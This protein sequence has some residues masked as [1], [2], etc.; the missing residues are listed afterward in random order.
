[1][2]LSQVVRPGPGQF[3][4]E[5]GALNY[6][7]QKL[8]SFTDP[9]IITGELSYQ[10]FKKHYSGSLDLP[11]F[12]YDGTASHE[13]MERLSSLIKGTDCVVGIGGGRALDTAKGTAALLKV[14]Y[15]TIPTVLGTCSAYTP[16]SAVYHPDHT[17]KVVDYYEKA[18]LLCLMDL[19]LL[20]E[21][22]KNY[23]MGGIGDTLAKWYEAEG[24]TRH[25]EGN[26][27]AMVQVGLRTAKATQEL[28]LKDSTEALKSLEN[29][30][31]TDAFKRVAETVIAIAGTVGGFAGEYGRMAGAHAVHNGMSL[32]QETHV[33]EHGVKVAYGVLIQLWASGDEKEVRKLL[34][35]FESN[36]FPH[37][38]SDFAVKNNFLEKAKKVAAFAASD[39]ETFKL[40]VPGVTKE[41]IFEAMNAVEDFSKSVSGNY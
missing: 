22:P 26:L 35:F 6:L 37:R 23:F 32:I 12:Q 13:D 29:T 34:L 10:A 9:I 5:S 25:V 31:V 33:F 3:L 14:E 30:E 27:P 39:N 2:R 7:D 17:F 21:S 18:A 38:F 36:H 15:V 19:D 16:L 20:V 8:A 41:A 28:L 4:C 1:M 24:I 11:V 40:A